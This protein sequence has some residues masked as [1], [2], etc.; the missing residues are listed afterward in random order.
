MKAENSL[1]D[2]VILMTCFSQRNQINLDT[3]HQEE[4]EEVK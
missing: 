2:S 1:Y 4:N 3:F